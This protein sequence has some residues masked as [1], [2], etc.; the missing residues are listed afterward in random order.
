MTLR[1]RFE[2]CVESLE[3]ALA[4]DAG[5]AN[6]LELCNN[7]DAG[8]ATP[9]V[10]LVQRVIEA[11]SI[12][13]FAMARPRPGSFVCDRADLSALERDVRSLRSAGAHGIVTGVLTCDGDIDTDAMRRLVDAARPLPVTFHR[14]FDAVGAL[15]RALDS[16]MALSVDRVLTSGGA[17]TAVEGAEVLARLTRRAGD[18]LTIVAGGGVRPH[19]VAAL[20]RASGVVE[21][22]ARLVT[23]RCETAPETAAARAAVAAM[24][25]ALV[26]T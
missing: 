18:Q 15:D 1:V 6:R 13:V 24:V 20:V 5:G 25:A 14:A 4:S 19:N 11:V 22:H 7:L 23:T 3:A 9:D 12:P 21:V 16:L 8:G 17:P 2:S 10:A 26:A